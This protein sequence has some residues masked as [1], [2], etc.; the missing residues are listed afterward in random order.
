MLDVTSPKVS[1]NKIL[2]LSR[3]NRGNDRILRHKKDELLHMDMFFSTKRSKTVWTGKMYSQLFVTG[4]N[5]T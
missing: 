3:K 4:K 1:R 5:F 2:S